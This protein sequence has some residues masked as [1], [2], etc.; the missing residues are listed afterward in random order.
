MAISAD[1]RFLIYS[2]IEEN[3]SPQAKPHLYLRRMDH[4]KAEPIAGT[5]GGINPFLSP[6]NRW[7]GFW[8]DGKLKKVLIEGG[9]PAT[10]CDSPGCF[11]ASWG[12]SNRV[13]FSGIVD[14]L[15]IVSAD[16]GGG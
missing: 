1:G 14:G 11:G 2:A 12:V 7:V 8:A 15:S 5:E 10:L 6:D 16:G 4:E 3:P 9:V 13:A